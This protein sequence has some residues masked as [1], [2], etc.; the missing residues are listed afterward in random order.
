M[1]RKRGGAQLVVP[2]RPLNLRGQPA[3]PQAPAGPLTTVQETPHDPPAAPTNRRAR[4]VIRKV[5]ETA[6]TAAERQPLV[7][8]EQRTDGAGDTQVSGGGASTRN[9]VTVMCL[10]KW[11]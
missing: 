7:T 9:V 4:F 6:A 8:P 11:R 1:A 2:R 5:D 10:C 3:G